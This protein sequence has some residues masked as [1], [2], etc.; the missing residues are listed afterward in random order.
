[1]TTP[2]LYPLSAP[3]PVAFFLAHLMPIGEQPFDP[4]NP[5]LGAERWRTGMRLPYRMVT[6]IPG[7]S[8]LISIFGRVRTHTFAE[9]YTGASQ[10]GDTTHQRM[11]LLADDPLIEVALPGGR[12]ASCES[13]DVSEI[14]HEEPYAAKSVITRFLSEYEFSLRLSPTA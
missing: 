8:D 2:L 13:L 4:A 14:P 3:A 5:D 10:A 9:T 6:L 11:L 12:I 7:R 1:M